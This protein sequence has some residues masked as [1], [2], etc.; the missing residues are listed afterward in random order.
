MIK[1]A[2]HTVIS[3]LAVAVLSVSCQQDDWQETLP[4][5]RKGY[6]A[7]RFNADIPVPEVQ[8]VSTRA[9]DPDG[10]GVQN[11]TLF[12]FDGYGLFTTTVSATVSSTGNMAGTFTAEVPENTRRVHFVANQNMNDFKEDHFRNKSESEVMALLEG[13]AGHMIY[14]AR[15]ACTPD[16]EGTKTTIASQ[17][18]DKGNKITML[19]NHA[20]ITID[21]PTNGAIVVTGM[22]AYNINAFGTVAPYHPEKGFTFTLD[23]WMN[24]DFV[25]LPQ[26][27]AKES[28][29]MDVTTATSQYIFEQENRSDDPVSIII[30][31][32]APGGSETDDKYYRVMLVDEKGD[33]IL[34]RRNHRYILHIAGALSFGQPTFEDALTAA[35]TNNVWISISDDVNEVED[36]NYILTVD[37]TYEVFDDS[38][39]GSE[40]TRTFVYTVAGKNGTEITE[41]D[42]PEISWLDN[43]VAAQ[44]IGGGFKIENGVGKGTI[45]I[46]LRSLG[47]NEK[48]EGTLL[49][50]HGLLQRKIKIVLLK[51]Q[52]FA[53]SW[54]G[55]AV[56]GG[57][58]S[59][60]PKTDRPHVS[61]MFTIPETC[62]E[63]LFPMNVYITASELD[64]RAASG[65]LLPIVRK[66]DTEWYSS[67]VIPQ[68]PDYKFVYR[69]ESPGV[70]RVYFENILT[71]S[72]GYEGTLYIE[73]EH[74]E[75]MKRTYV[76][77]DTRNSITV[78]NLDKYT[79]IAST[80]D[81]AKD[82]YVY[83]CVVPQKKYA[84]VQFDMQLRTKVGDEMGDVQGK[85]INA[86]ANDEFLFYTQHLNN[87][88]YEIGEIT[89]PDCLF[90]KYNSLADA[91]MQANNP[92]GGRMLMFKPQNPS[93]SSGGTGKYRLDMYTNRAKS[94]EV[95]RIA[96][97]L[98]H[99]PAVAPDDANEAGLYK[100]EIYR[101]TTFELY[102]YNPFRFGARVKYADKDWAGAAEEPDRISTRNDIPEKI[103]PL[104]W[105]YQ[106]EQ[107][108]DIA[109]DVTSFHHRG[110]NGKSV[111]VHPFADSFGNLDRGEHFEIYIDAPML[112]IDESRLAENK[113]NGTKLKADPSVLGRFIYTADINRDTE[114]QYGTDDVANKDDSGL[115]D[116][117]GERKTLPFIVNS[118]VSAGDIVISSNEEKVVFYAKTFRVTNE[119]IKGTIKYRDDDDG[120][121]KEVPDN[122]FVA[123]ERTT[124]SNR[125][126]AVNIPSVGQYELRLRKEYPL[127]WYG[128]PV[129]FHYERDG[130]VY[131]ARYNS[132][133]EMFAAQQ[134][135][136]E[137]VLLSEN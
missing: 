133:A 75:T 113:L 59:D 8:S 7:L 131:H 38:N 61:L 51:K 11:M 129:A 10:G 65:M 137:V 49:V 118:I 56:Y 57:L 128:Y 53:P 67:G 68:A 72:S 63:E 126:G 19:R 108:V 45:I 109:I 87:Y 35:A 97:N 81:L 29:I 30:R 120:T 122:A 115:A 4:E 70:Q 46:S 9:V 23:E 54:V 77:S 26:K 89:A 17:M 73:A 93:S 112:K 6:V 36:T 88:N 127:N 13:S 20:L 98:N 102:N 71:Q 106:P 14:W 90:S 114:R 27:D 66:G 43:S 34:V 79:A 104:T 22:A 83:Y 123:F 101:S 121:L 31:G 96:S 37:K 116:Q 136:D 99:Y 105:T 80:N 3:L 28:D 134:K 52:S 82:E 44:G 42:K 125:I 107:K 24:D 117:T 132:L 74:F 25:T 39:I 95:V 21:N 76:F 2:I 110:F 16:A 41:A 111:S 84:H 40:R 1:K 48:Q 103:T 135:G 91:W 92:E 85:A 5:A 78:E 47:G 64:I 94:A 100:G 18:A 33:Q 69:V 86:K 12:C 60:D 32:Y 130:R 119:S 124:N 62:P 58:N 15:F 55:T 50:K